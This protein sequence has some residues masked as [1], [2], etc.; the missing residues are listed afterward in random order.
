M[1]RAIDDT[2]SNWM[3]A[4]YNFFNS[5]EGNFLVLICIL[6]LLLVYVLSVAKV[7]G[8]YDAKITQ[9]A[10]Q[11]CDPGWSIRHSGFPPVS[12]LVGTHGRMKFR[13]AVYGKGVLS[14][15]HLLLQGPTH[16]S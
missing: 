5:P 2:R 15:A 9:L 7:R 14:K 8:Q 10:E 13:Y 11:V 6:G 3:Q 16:W 1:A 12:I 4:R